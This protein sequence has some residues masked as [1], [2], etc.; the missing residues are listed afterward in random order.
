[1]VLK[2]TQ[3]LVPGFALFALIAK[4]NLTITFIR[5]W[6]MG[7]DVFLR[8]SFHIEDM[9]TAG[10]CVFGHVRGDVLRP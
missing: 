9:E 5:L 10:Q 3:G 4:L 1:M 6:L 8:M 2:T 7:F